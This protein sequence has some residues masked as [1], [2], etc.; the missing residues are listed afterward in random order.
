MLMMSLRKPNPDPFDPEQLLTIQQ[1][2]QLMQCGIQ[3]IRNRIDSGTFLAPTHRMGRQ[4][5]WR[6]MDVLE[7]MGRFRTQ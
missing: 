3:T 4:I 1:V 7:Y 2:A 5:R 6:R